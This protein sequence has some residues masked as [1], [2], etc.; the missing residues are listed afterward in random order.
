MASPEA[1]FCA[2]HVGR[3][4]YVTLTTMWELS[5]AD[6]FY[7]SM[8]LSRDR[9]FYGACVDVSLYEISVN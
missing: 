5:I 8:M 9:S 2:G 4:G 1:G 6:G 7:T 3:D